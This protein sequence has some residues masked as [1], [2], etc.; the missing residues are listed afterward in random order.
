MKPI[1]TKPSKL[2]PLSM[3]TKRIICMAFES[4]VWKRRGFVAKTRSRNTL[5]E[6]FVTMNSNTNAIFANLALG[7][8]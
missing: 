5:N 1:V 7:L 6:S 3:I 4:K 2:P 8:H